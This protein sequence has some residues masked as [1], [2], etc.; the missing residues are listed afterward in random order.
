MN[1]FGIVIACCKWDIRYAKACLASIRYFLRDVPVCF[2]VDGPASL[3][4]SIKKSDP[5][6]IVLSVDSLH[7]PWLRKACRGYGHTK[8]AALW[9]AP[10]DACLYLDADTCVWGDILS[11]IPDAQYDLII[12][13]HEI[14]P[15][16]CQPGCARTHV[17]DKEFAWQFFNPEKLSVHFP[18]FDFGAH[19]D[20]YAIT[21]TFFF[22]RGA[23]DLAAYQQAWVL[24]QEDSEFF[25]KGEQGIL[26]FLI[27]RGVQKNELRVYSM[28]FQVL[29]LPRTGEEMRLE[30][31]PLCLT[32]KKPLKPAVLHFVE[33]PHIFTRSARGAT[34]NHFRLQYLLQIE[35]LPR[36]KA[37]WKMALEDITHIT[38]QFW[39]YKCLRP[40]VL[41]NGLKRRLR[42]LFRWLSRVPLTMRVRSKQTG[43]ITYLDLFRNFGLVA[44]RQNE[45]EEFRSFGLLLDRFRPEIFWDVGANIGRYSLFFLSRRPN[46]SVLAFEPDV[47]NL[48]LFYRTARRNALSSIKIVPKAVAGQT[49]ETTFFLDDIHGATGTIIPN[50]FFILDRYGATPK[51]MRVQT[52]TLDEQLQ[53]NEGPDLIKID[54]EGAELSALEGGR[55]MLERYLPVILYHASINRGETATLLNNLGYRLFTARTLRSIDYPAGTTIALHEQKHLGG[56]R[57]L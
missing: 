37:L 10:F 35:G 49:G 29:A 24:Q 32:G 43:Y 36:W 20:R 26:N 3:C 51:P 17:D 15:A 4:D 45:I 8:M 44:R 48:N 9:E 33:K 27:F 40:Y 53:E 50:N 46:G 42:K 54:V 12:D 31:S 11:T 55:C 28:P 47:R 57:F 21:G 5:H 25:Y 22:R 52:T 39:Y 14:H 13:R 1:S 6:V 7:N 56:Q 38:R 30:Y 34:M 18:E 19:R 16:S 23:M 41:A 2:L